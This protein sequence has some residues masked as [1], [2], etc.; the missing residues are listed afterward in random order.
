M[1]R[2]KEDATGEVFDDVELL[3][4]AVFGVDAGFEVGRVG[5][6]GGV[7]V[8]AQEDDGGV[9]SGGFKPRLYF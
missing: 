8:V 3:A 7:D 1:T 4:Q 5:Q 6:A 9:L 2:Q